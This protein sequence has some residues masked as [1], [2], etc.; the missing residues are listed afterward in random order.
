MR[1]TNRLPGPWPFPTK[2]AEVQSC[3]PS[4]VAPSF[5]SITG[6]AVKLSAGLSHTSIVS[7]FPLPTSS[8]AAAGTCAWSSRPSKTSDCPT[9]PAVKDGLPKSNTWLL[10][11]RSSAV[12]SRGHQATMPDGGGKQTNGEATSNAPMSQRP[13]LLRFPSGR[14]RP[15]WS[16]AAQESPPLPGPAGF[17]ASIAGLPGSKARVSVGPPL[18]FSSPSR[19]SMGF[20]PSPVWSPT[21]LVKPE[22]SLMPIRL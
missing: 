7:P 21:A 1:F 15:R 18:S 6:W 10:P 2:S 11:W 13:A 5:H 3:T 17:A 9:L 22:P 8:A 19:G 12:P 14:L 16:V 4:K 20:V